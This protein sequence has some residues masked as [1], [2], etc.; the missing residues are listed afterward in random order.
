M[1]PAALGQGPPDL[2]ERPLGL[3][4]DPHLGADC[5]GV[6]GGRLQLEQR[7]LQRVPVVQ[8]GHVGERPQAD[9]QGQRLVD[10]EPQRPGD[11]VGVAEVDVAV[12][13][14]DLD[15]VVRQVAGRAAHEQQLQVLDQLGLGDPELAAASVSGM[16]CRLTR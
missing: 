10:A 12:V 6:T 9:E 5:R 1:H 16:P 14:V 7:A 13:P 3:H 4:L 11:G 15:Q 8:A 2:G